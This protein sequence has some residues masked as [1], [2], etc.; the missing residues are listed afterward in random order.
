MPILDTDTSPV[1]DNEPGTLA[2]TQSAGEPQDANPAQSSGADVEDAKQD[3][4]TLRDIIQD[5]VKKQEA[6]EDSS[7]PEAKTEESA[8]PDATA[9]GDDAEPD[10]DVP[11]HNHP[12]FKELVAE[13][14][15]FKEDAEQYRNI[16]TFM[17]QTGLVAEEVAEGFEVMALLKSGTPDDLSKARDWFATRLQFLDETLGHSLPEDLRLKIEDG[18]LDEATAKEV[19]QS[20]ATTKLLQ[21]QTTEQRERQEQ[22]RQQQVK[23]QT[24]QEMVTAVSSWEADIK[25]Q[26]PDYAAKKAPL[27]ETQVRALIQER[28]KAPQSSAEALEYVKSAYA[29][30]NETL[31]SLVP[32]PKPMTPSPAGMSAAARP[33]PTSLRGAVE[34]ALNR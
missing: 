6:P 30:V 13:R 8:E 20:R 27:V 34:A 2:E 3:E 16:T 28:G 17:T 7:T 23:Q 31:K 21:T 12:R 22:Q 14:N 4:P 26:D 1:L 29:R 19:A 9:E 24:Q 10:A 11:F 15:A 25:V 32:K 5:V 33:E 18:L